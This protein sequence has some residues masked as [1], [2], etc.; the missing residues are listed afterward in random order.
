MMGGCCGQKNCGACIYYSI[1]P[2]TKK[3]WCDMKD[4]TVAAGDQ[5]CPWF[6]PT[7]GKCG[8]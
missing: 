2:K 5:V 6:R 7:E 8:C 3:G 1:E 4:K